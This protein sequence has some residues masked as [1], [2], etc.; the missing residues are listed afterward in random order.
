M[1]KMRYGQLGGDQLD[2]GERFRLRHARPEEA[3]RHVRR[4]PSARAY[5][6]G[7]WS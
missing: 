6:E 4:A 2:H 1:T 3:E 5:P 7:S